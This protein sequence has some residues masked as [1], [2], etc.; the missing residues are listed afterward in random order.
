M[1]QRS[2]E[3]RQRLLDAAARLFSQQGYDATG[4]AQICASA[5]VSKGAFYHHFETKQAVFLALLEEWLARLDA[6]FTA[7]R[8]DSTDMPQAVVRMADMAGS[9]L[10]SSGVQLSIML[11]FWMQAYRDPQVWEAAAA[12]YQRYQQ[13]FA[14][15]V[16][17]GM[18]QGSLRPV[19]PQMA[20]RTLVSLA[21]G[22]LLQAVF[23]PKAT[24]WASEAGGA[25]Q[26]VMDG[27][28]VRS[29]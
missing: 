24:D 22:L 25:L 26:L 18:R 20:A 4:V 8:Q 28:A 11:E 29:A 9:V 6:A 21:M 17:E 1:Q 10:T 19:D 14:T 23:D 2:Q 7:V 5:G 3:T 13:Y 27:L 15:L 16:E 12:P